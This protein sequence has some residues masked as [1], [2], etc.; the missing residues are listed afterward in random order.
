MLLFV[1]L[2]VG[3]AWSFI[4]VTSSDD[5]DPPPPTV[6]TT[7][8]D[9]TLPPSTTVPADQLVEVGE[10]WL[11][12]RGDDVYDWGLSVAV[13]D[14]DSAGGGARSGV[15]VTVSLLD[16]RDD[17]VA[18]IVRTL[19]GVNAVAPSTIAGQLVDPDRPPTRIEFDITVGAPSND[20]ALDALLDTR[21]VRRD[22]AEITGRIRSSAL[23]DI[24]DVTMVM[25]WRSDG[26][27]SSGEA[28]LVVDDIIAVVTYEIERIRPGIDAQFTID[29]D[30]LRAPDGEPDDVFWSPSS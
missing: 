26:T 4:A 19:D 3:V 22:G 16:D 21:A 27:E 12:D 25:V 1:G 17:V 24:E 18:T 23:I 30:E 7:T 6:A 20:L 15:E 2:A 13:P 9:L 10:V 28:E 5:A 14:T 11:L 8:T 29:L